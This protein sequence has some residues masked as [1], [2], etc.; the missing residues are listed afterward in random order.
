MMDEVQTFLNKMKVIEYGWID[1]NGKKYLNHLVKDKFIKDYYLQNPKDVWKT[2][3]GICWDQVEVE[4]QFFKEK[5]I[6][7]QSIFM[8]YD[9]GLKYP[10]HTF[11]LFK[12]DNKYGWIE[13]TY[14]YVKDSIR[15]Y[16]SIKEAIEDVT[17]EF[18]RENN[19]KVIGDK[20]YYF[21]YDKPKY[22][23]DFNGY[24]NHCRSSKLLNEDFSNLEFK[25]VA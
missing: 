17:K 7:H 5:K 20:I 13:N 16:D 8:F 4:R 22:G 10:I 12:L 23:L 19:L 1:K 15:Y 21:N 6:P 25:K 24:I 11:L 2:Q 18:I 14:T 3:I 9:D